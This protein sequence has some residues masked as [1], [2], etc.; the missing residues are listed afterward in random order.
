MPGCFASLHSLF[1]CM[2]SDVFCAIQGE[3]TVTD[4]MSETCSDTN[5]LD[6]HVM[7]LNGPPGKALLLSVDYGLFLRVSQAV[8][9]FILQGVC[10]KKI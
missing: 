7:V 10:N 6:Q 1:I 3:Y 5:L 4:T 2:N 9:H 8:F